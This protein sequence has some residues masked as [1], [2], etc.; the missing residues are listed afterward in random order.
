MARK[1][2][3][4][5]YGIDVQGGVEIRRKVV[6]GQVVPN[7]YQLEEGTYEEVTSG[8]Q[9]YGQAQEPPPD[10]PASEPEDE[11]EVEEPAAP[12]PKARKKSSKGSEADA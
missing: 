1:A 8:V 10:K 6:A 5:T 4:N 12:A 2:I 11:P 3:K 9:T 7:S